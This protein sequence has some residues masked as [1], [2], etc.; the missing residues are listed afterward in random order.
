MRRKDREI[1]E[2]E[3]VELLDKSEYGVLSTVDTNGQPYGV[4][5][6][7]VYKDNAIYFH[8]AVDGQKLDNIANNSKVSFCVTGKTTVLP[9]T[10]GTL[11]ESAVVFGVAREVHSEERHQ[12]LVW[13]LEKYCSDFIAGGLQY[14]ESKDKITK[15]IKIEISQ[16]SG[17]ARRG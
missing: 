15:V 6:S 7:Y 10:F 11:Y 12:A 4:P 1:S 17:K 2:L 3:A 5:L 16:V 14:I 13:L 9:E 8:C